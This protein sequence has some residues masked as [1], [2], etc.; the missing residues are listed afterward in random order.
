MKNIL[1]AV[2]ANLHYSQ[3]VQINSTKKLYNNY[4]KNVEMYHVMYIMLCTTE[5]TKKYGENYYCNTI[6]MLHD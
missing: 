2:N 4:A 1:L 6:T 5:C 3:N